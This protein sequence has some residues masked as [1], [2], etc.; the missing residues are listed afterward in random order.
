MKNGVDAQFVVEFTNRVTGEFVETLFTPEKYLAGKDNAPNVP[1]GGF[2]VVKV[3]FDELLLTPPPEFVANIL[4][5]YVDPGN[6]FDISIGSVRLV[7]ELEFTKGPPKR[8]AEPIVEKFVVYE[9]IVK[10]VAGS[11]LSIEVGGVT[12]IL[13]LDDVGTPG[14]KFVT[15]LG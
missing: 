9:A 13:I 5:L 1:A 8:V 3:P 15:S 2:G 10:E 7:L 14:T 12:F 6:K 11:V 4:K